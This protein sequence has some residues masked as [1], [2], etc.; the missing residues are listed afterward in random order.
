MQTVAALHSLI[1]QKLLVCDL[2]LP[3]SIVLYLCLIE[4]IDP[5]SNV[6][7][8]WTFTNPVLGNHW[9]AMAKDHRA[10][11]FPIW[12]Y[13]DDTSGNLSKKWNEHN[14]YLFT[15]AGLPRAESSKEYNIHFLCTSNIAPPLEMMEG[16]LKQ[17]E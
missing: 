16:V 3:S 11:A 8:P 1:R 5:V 2:Y 10:V 12:L 15:P 9:R 7:S 13:C 17:L 4:C 14:S 6:Q